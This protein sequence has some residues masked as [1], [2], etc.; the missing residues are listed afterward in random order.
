[1]VGQIPKTKV[2]SAST[3]TPT[4]RKTS[5]SKS[6]DKPDKPEGTKSKKAK[7]SHVKKTANTAEEVEVI[8]GEDGVDVNFKGPWA[9][10]A[11]PFLG[12]VN[13]GSHSD[14]EIRGKRFPTQVMFAWDRTVSRILRK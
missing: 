1:M 7:R 14:D 5:R 9:A 12:F 11:E 10:L 8:E 4:N 6:P 2:I 3:P 13:R